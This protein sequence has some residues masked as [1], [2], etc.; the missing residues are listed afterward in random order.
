MN[1]SELINFK[2]TFE[3]EFETKL[4]A[5]DC[6]F[7]DHLWNGFDDEND[8]K[9]ITKEDFEAIEALSNKM[10]HMMFNIGCPNSI[11]P[12]LNS[13][14]ERKLKCWQAN[15]LF[16][17]GDAEWKKKGYQIKTRD[18]R[19]RAIKNVERKHHGNNII[20][21]HFRW[22][23]RGYILSRRATDLLED[24]CSINF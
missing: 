11:E 7:Q 23:N 22:N 2:L 8:P 5:F 20:K 9:F 21:G 18:C 15:E 13:I 19:N 12:M 1:L 6:F 14:I 16:L 10:N 24:Y 3:K 4:L 17:G